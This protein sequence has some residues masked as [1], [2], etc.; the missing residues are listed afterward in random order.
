MRA[1]AVI[2]AVALFAW[3]LLVLVVAGRPL[4]TD[5]FWWH[6]ALGRN[7]AQL[8]PWL[9]SDPLLHTTLSPPAPASWLF[10]VALHG[11]WTAAGFQGLRA[12]HVGLVLGITVLVAWLAWRESRSDLP[13]TALATACFLALS[14]YRLIQ[15]RPELITI[16]VALALFALLFAPPVAPTRARVGTAIALIALN[17]NAHAGF[18]LGPILV[19][20]GTLGIVV[21]ARIEDRAGA[22]A[23]CEA[24]RARAT[25]IA[26]VL[27]AGLAVALLNPV[28]IRQHLAPFT[29]F[30]EPRLPLVLDEWSAFDPFSLPSPAMRMGPLAWGIANLLAVS[31]AVAALAA[32]TAWARPS[33]RDRMLRWATHDVPVRLAL[34]VAAIAAMLLAI[35][36]HWLGVFPALLWL[37]LASQGGAARTPR[38]LA[39]RWGSAVAT[40][41]L[42]CAAPSAG[43][44]R[45]SALGVPDDMES[46]LTMPYAARKYHAHAVWFLSDA[47]LSGHLF[48]NYYMGGFLGFWLA[49]RIQTFVNGTLN[50]PPVRLLEE[51][52]SVA[53]GRSTGSGRSFLD[54]LRGAEVDLF[55]GTGLP[56]RRDPR[57]PARYTTALLDDTEDWVLAFR[58]VDSAVYVRR[59]DAGGE[60][61]DRVAAYY[62]SRG[63][64]FDRRRGFDPALVLRERPE[65]AL[66]HGIAPEDYPALVTRIGDADPATR[67]AALEQLGSLQAA[68]G[69]YADGITTEERITGQ[70]P[71][72][73]SAHR[74]RIFD[75][76]H[77]ERTREALRHAEALARLGIRDPVVD[78]YALIARRAERGERVPPLLPLF[79][80]DEA[81]RLRA[82]VRPPPLRPD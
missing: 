65:W 62:A 4:E 77:L 24:S 11:V 45:P 53:R 36:L 66:A 5:D 79:E 70:W 16:F 18:L 72:A 12:L 55:L 60:N 31:V 43:R 73:V 2:V 39:L 57:L 22:N 10:D 26:A 47:D 67:F 78:G 20:A 49:P 58:S 15:L 23:A 38:H 28:G 42:L 80:S 33:A 69:L 82:S 50:F 8:G 64:A 1:S 81:A 46:Y 71:R 9:G 27:A 68:L 51:Y 7:Y 3:T 21:R 29:A 6:L 40:L 63:I 56:E 54:V 59:E 44:L 32:A 61:L 74:R 30:F 75:L 19:A 76:L 25:R 34:A 35:R 52:E 17:A 41:L 13:L 14:W 37:C 48:A